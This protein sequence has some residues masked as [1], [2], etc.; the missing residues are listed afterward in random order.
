[1]KAMI[2]AAGLGTR[3]LPLTNQRPKPLFPVCNIPLLG[4]IVNQLKGFGV[5]DLAVNT[6]WL[7]PLVEDYLG[8]QDNFSININISHEK[9]LLGTAG[10]IK[11][12]EDFWGD[13]P[14]LVVT[15]DIFHNIDLKSV[16]DHHR[17]RNNLATLIVHHYPRF[18]RVEMD[19]ENNIVGLRGKRLKNTSSSIFL[20]AFTG[21]HVISPELLGEFPKG[22]KGDIINLYQKLIAKGAP[23]KG[24][25]AK[26]IYWQDMGSFEDYHQLHR[27]LLRG[28]LREKFEIFD[29][30]EY[31]NRGSHADRNEGSIFKGYVFM[32]NHSTIGRGCVIKDSVIWNN[33]EIADNLSIEN[34]IVGDGAVIKTSLKNEVVAGDL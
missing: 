14:F 19:G 15:G 1:M 18:N 33:V 5:T 28:E 9:E 8:K 13:D 10:G 31:H 29:S 26:D 3:L 20:S 16:Y 17:E 32:G 7:A 27:D 24:F 21:I 2:L 30:L 11:K 4:I 22:E 34:C 12:L 6:H 23:I 25:L